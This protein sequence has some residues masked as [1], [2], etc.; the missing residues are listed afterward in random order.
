EAMVAEMREIGPNALHAQVL[1]RFAGQV[2]RI[3]PPEIAKEIFKRSIALFDDSDDEEINETIAR[4]EGTLRRLDLP[5]NTMDLSGTLLNGEAF[6][7]DSYRGKV[8][9]VD[10]WATWCPPCIGEL[11][12]VLEM[13]EAYHDQ[14]FEVVGISLDDSETKVSGFVEARDIPWVTLF[15]AEESD[16]GWNHP[17]ARRYGISG[18]PTAILLD[19]DGKVVHMNARGGALRSELQEL[20]GDPPAVEAA[21]EAAAP[22]SEG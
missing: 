18:I 19:R 5:G 16:R 14:G 20:L 8:V 15:P 21:I 9:L 13:Y 10:F 17:M 12:N 4:M 2:E 11:P 1:L 22:G 6:D 7:W 3:D